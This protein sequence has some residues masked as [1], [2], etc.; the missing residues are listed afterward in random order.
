MSEIKGKMNVRGF[1]EGE[2]RGKMRKVRGGRDA[3]I[4]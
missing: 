4:D 3:K 1:E 2:V